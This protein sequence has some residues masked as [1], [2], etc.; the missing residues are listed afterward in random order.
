MLVKLSLGIPQIVGSP[1]LPRRLAQGET[2]ILLDG[3]VA[4]L[5]D[6]VTLRFEGLA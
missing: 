4:E 2:A 6:G 1:A 5:G 3:D